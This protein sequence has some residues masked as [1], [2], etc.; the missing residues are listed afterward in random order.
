MCNGEP[1]LRT[2]GPH[3]LGRLRNSFGMFSID[4]AHFPYRGEPLCSQRRWGLIQL[5]RMTCAHVPIPR[6]SFDLHDR[7]LFRRGWG[8]GF[9]P[10]THRRARALRESPRPPSA[11]HVVHVFACFVHFLVTKSL[12]MF[13]RANAAV[14]L[15]CVFAAQTANG[16]WFYRVCVR[17]TP[18]SHQG[19]RSSSDSG[20]GLPLLPL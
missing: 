8:L 20:T 3:Y 2:G 19:K 13:P 14:Y 10:R 18:N 11:S 15:S 12:N 4:P 9:M 1:R 17:M 16:C 7:R 6:F 5:C